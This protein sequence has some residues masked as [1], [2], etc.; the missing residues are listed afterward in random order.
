MPPHSLWSGCSDSAIYLA[1]C[2]S[3]GWSADLMN[4]CPRCPY[5][6]TD[7]LLP[8]EGHERWRMLSSSLS[9]L[10][11][12]FHM[13]SLQSVAG[14]LAL[15]QSSYCLLHFTQLTLREHSYKDK[16]PCVRDTHS[17]GTIHVC[18]CKPRGAFAQP[19]Q[20]THTPRQPT[21]YNEKTIVITMQYTC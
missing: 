18:V 14:L 19:P 16:V 8:M 21:I 15:Q 11:F 17:M 9:F 2:R 4:T 13:L 5:T 12:L 7:P 10:F 20:P 6:T 3:L 1:N